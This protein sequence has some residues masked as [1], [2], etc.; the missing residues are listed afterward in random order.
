VDQLEVRAV[1]AL[2]VWTGAVND[3]WQNPHNW[4]TSR[5][6]ASGDFAKINFGSPVLQGVGYAF[7]VDVAAGAHLTLANGA[8]GVFDCVNQG[9][10]TME[11]GSSATRVLNGGLLT[12]SGVINTDLDNSGVYNTRILVGTFLPRGTFTVNGRFQSS[13]PGPP[14]APAAT[15]EIDLGGPAPGTGYDQLIVTGEVDPGRLAVNAA[16]D[17]VPGQVFRIIDNR[18]LNA[19]HGTFDGLPE[20]AT[21][22]AGGQQFQISYVGGDGNDVTLTRE[23]IGDTFRWDGQPDGG[24]TSADNFWSD[25]MNWVGDVAPTPG[26]NLVFPAGVSQSS[27][28]NDFPAD[29]AFSLMSILGSGYDFSGNSVAFTAGVNAEIASGSSTLGLPLIGSGGLTK[30]GAGTLVLSGANTF[31]GTTA[32]YGG[33]LDL[34]RTSGTGLAG[35]LGVYGGTVRELFA[36]QISDT[37]AVTVDLGGSFDLNGQLDTIGTFTAVSGVVQTAGGRLT[38]GDTSLDANSTLAMNLVDATTSDRITVNGSVAVG[39]TLSLSP[40]TPIPF[41]TQITLIDNDGTDAVTGSFSNA[42]EGAIVM[43]NGSPFRITYRGGVDQND[44]VVTAINPSSGQIAG[45]VYTDVNG[46]GRNNSDPSRDGVTVQLDMGADGSVDQTTTTANGGLYSFSDLP[47]GRFRIRMVAPGGTVQTSFNPSDVTLAIAQTVGGVDFGVFQLV[48][49][50]G[51][52]FNDRNGDGIRNN[53]EP[54][55]GGVEMRIFPAGGGLIIQTVLTNSDGTFAFSNIGP[56]SFDVQELIPAGTSQTTRDPA[57]ITTSSGLDVTG[58]LFGN[59]VNHVELFAVAEGAGGKP[60]VNVYNADGSLRFTLLAYDSRF[61]GGVRV[62]TGDVNGDGVDDII[63]APGAGGG[64][65]IEV[66]D[67]ATS[68]LLQSFL[69][70]SPAF[71]GGVYVAVGDVNND[72]FGDIITGA[73]AGGGPHV[74]VFNGTNHALLHSFFA[75]SAKFTGGVR[76]AAGDVNDDRFGDIITGA[77]AGG[78]PHVEVFS[79][80]NLSLLKSIFAFDPSF[81]GGVYVAAGDVDNDKYADLIVGAGEGGGPHVKVYSG[82]LDALLD[83]FFAY[84]SNFRGGVRVGAGDVNGD[85]KDDIITGAGPGGGPHVKVTTA[86]TLHEM[87]SFMAFDPTFLG[88]VFVG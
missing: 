19:V 45:M 1:P 24:G 77:G 86:G 50:S 2:I 42:A 6:P 11:A 67:G 55:V 80:V 70:Y 87:D 52:K 5:V 31:T 26:A 10:L 3:F 47:A 17:A 43:A 84:D 32:L 4:S 83:N 36:D 85:G 38:V 29:T 71:T 7:V 39:G 76:V 66:F 22:A 51:T 79:G 56:G 23:P 12:G 74:E 9:E 46:N 16:F 69:A 21:L 35:D 57:T 25:S 78:G 63:T 28:V 8:T 20:G 30:G 49:V 61:T 81:T 15:L 60:N 88:G 48:S 68:T 40:T 62:A 14:F 18:G 37:S 33:F 41:G 75:Y 72:G 58:I 34:A 53:N 65:H 73:G 59:R 13:S 44:V 27:T 54:G 82:R 64:P